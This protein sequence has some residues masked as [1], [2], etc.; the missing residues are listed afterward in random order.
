MNELELEL[1]DR[2]NNTMQTSLNDTS[3]S[4][5]SNT[6]I[7]PLLQS[8]KKRICKNILCLLNSMLIVLMSV[9]AL[10]I[11]YYRNSYP[12]LGRIY[13]MALPRTNQ[14][15]A[16]HAYCSNVADSQYPTVVLEHGGGGN[17]AGFMPL[18]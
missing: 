10:T 8:K 15:I 1:G 14:S 3:H 12:A 2:K 9:N 11:Y 17:M 6:H 5:T 4:E 18:V 13:E 7:P 16:F